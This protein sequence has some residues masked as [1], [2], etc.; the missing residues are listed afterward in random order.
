MKAISQIIVGFGLVVIVGVVDAQESTQALKNGSSERRSTLEEVLVTGSQIRSVENLT[1][2]LIVLDREYIELSGVSSVEQLLSTV[3]QNFSSETGNFGRAASLRGLGPGTTLTLLNGRRMALDLSGDQADISAIPLSAIERVDILTDGASALYG[4]DA[5]GGVV[6]FI[7]R[8]DFQGIETHIRKGWADGVDERSA[9]L[10]AGTAWSSGHALIS[11]EYHSRNLLRRS[12]QEFVPSTSTVMALTPQEERT[13]VMFYGE[14]ALGENVIAFADA[15]YTKRN[16]YFV[17]PAVNDA[18]DR[19]KIPAL[20]SA[21]GLNWGLPREWLVEV[22]GAYARS[23]PED[24]TR[25]YAFDFV[26]SVLSDY[27]TY[28]GK[29]KADGPVLTLPGGPV[30]VAMGVDWRSESFTYTGATFDR[31]ARSAFGELYVPVVGPGNAIQGI[32]GLDLSLAGRYDEYSDFGS[33]FNPRL[34]I[35][36]EPRNGLVIR[37]SYGTSYVPPSLLFFDVRGLYTSVSS[38]PDPGLGGE[39]S[40]KLNLTGVN[41]VGVKAQESKNTS[42]GVQ[43]TPSGISGLQ[44]GASYYKID[45]SQRIDAPQIDL[46]DPA[47]Y[48][49]NLVIR[50]PSLTQVNEYI[51]IANQGFFDTSQVPDF[52]PSMVNV[53]VDGRLINLSVERASGFDISGQYA[54]H[55]GESEISLGLAG[56]YIKELMQQTTPTSLPVELVDTY[57]HPQRWAMRASAGWER[58]GWIANLFV[59]HKDSYKQRDTVDAISI[60][61]YTT[62]DMRLAYDFGTQSGPFSGL[63]VA[64][65]AQNL[66]DRDPPRTEVTGAGDEYGYDRGNVDPTGRL[67][68]LELQKAW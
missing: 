61:S 4:A 8:K 44:L 55:A 41:P 31:I 30:Q 26:S 47:T 16:G 24:T 35:A 57:A 45:Y 53:I 37:A 66:F 58:Q 67:I 6:N 54:F 60:S 42:F 21:L 49:S 23:K 36:W 2:P 19:H 38:D 52:D 7:L 22:S 39:N 68:A 43:W 14:Q 17:F 34:G 64:I 10:T 13:S 33:S 62:I 3:P 1:T 59:N 65:A 56:T 12:D 32:Q 28:S 63:E 15:L 51:A 5:V 27:K 29:V 50:D 46:G 18:D 48:T 9:N 20:Q 11:S 40:V 25:Y